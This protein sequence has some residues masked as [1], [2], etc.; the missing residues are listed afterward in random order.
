MATDYKTRLT[1]D[2][3]Q[4]DNAL[5]KSASQ[6]YQYKKQTDSAKAT[7]GKLAS[8]FGP[9]AAQVGLAGGALAV[10]TKA[11]RSTEQGSDALDSTLY[12]ARSSVNKF[13]QSLTS[14]SFDGFIGGLSD[15]VSTAKEAYNALDNLGTLRMWSNARVEQLKAQIAEARVVV[16]N[17]NSSASDKKKAQQTI[18]LN[19]QKIQALT[20]DIVEQ[21]LTAATA[22]LREIA[23]TSKVSDAQLEKYLKM[24]ESGELG[25]HYAEFTSA[26]SYQ[27]PYTVV[28]TE[29]APYT[30]YETKWD[31]ESNR[32]LANA[33][34]ALMTTKESE[35]QQYYDLLTQAAQLQQNTANQQNKANQLTT[36][37]S[38]SGSGSGV[39]SPT[40][41]Q[42]SIADIEAQIKALQ[43]RLKNEVLKSSE[44][45]VIQRQ[46]DVLEEKKQ[47]I[48]ESR[49][50]VERMEQA[51]EQVPTLDASIID[52]D[53]IAAE[54]QKAIDAIKETGL[55]IDDLKNLES[56]GD[57]F[58]YIGDM[59]SSLSETVGDESGK[60]FSAVGSSISAIGTAI[61]KIS[62]LMMAEGAASV[63]DLPYPAN[64]A[65]LA[66][67]IA[68]VTGVIGSIASIA[69]QQF[70]EGGIVRGATTIG[71]FVPARLNAGEMV[72]NTH[73][74]ERLFRMLNNPTVTTT[75]SD[76]ADVVFTIH[77][78]DLQ[79]TLN[80]YNRKRGRVI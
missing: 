33:M 48:E 16:N 13:F 31:S 18:D 72:L 22:K 69:N 78:A 58:G 19:M 76:G 79:G 34:A 51:I 75:M 65:A 26:H 49:K 38:G 57:S 61:A 44:V 60:I 30:M 70:A 7:L 14:G 9:L 27:S 20:G 77:G 50:P 53:G 12:T 11:L 67:V 45:M 1:A 43:D 23:G 28:P 55:T 68:A 56:V 63:M 40:Y 42:G 5:K 10:F 29:G 15:I 3:S 54:L 21:T 6:V 52:G 62:S 8:K 64:L 47:L 41:E 36:K 73:Q 39:K 80:N 35:L 2:T 66:S 24:W 74:Q 32:I 4:H 46:I 71:D 25:T 59:F 37:G 17:A